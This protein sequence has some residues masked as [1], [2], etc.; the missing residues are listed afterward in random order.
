MWPVSAS[1]MMRRCSA[2]STPT[3]SESRSAD[4]L[5]DCVLNRT[6]GK[7]GLTVVFNSAQEAAKPKRYSGAYRKGSKQM[8]KDRDGMAYVEI[9]DL[10]AS[11]VLVLASHPEKEVGAVV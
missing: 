8:V 1:W 4:V 6:D 3:A 11:Q 5:V 10:T 9:R 2:S 7:G